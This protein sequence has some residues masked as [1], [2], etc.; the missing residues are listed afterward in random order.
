[1]TGE[2]CPLPTT[3]APAEITA[4]EKMLDAKTI[5]VVGISND[6]F[7]PS[8]Y[9][10]EYLAEHGYEIIPIN[11]NHDQVLE[12]KCLASLSALEKGPDVVL[13]F[14]R[15]EQCAEVA[16][17]AAAIGAKAIWL[18]SGIHSDEARRI[19]TDAGMDYVE[20]RCMMI[21]HGG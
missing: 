4:I 7:R 10:S 9:V 6:P 19:A 16:R 8:R 18:P 1:M 20:G 3:P 15:S 5:A 17:Q 12:R 2:A 13:V 14:R 11:P 21:E